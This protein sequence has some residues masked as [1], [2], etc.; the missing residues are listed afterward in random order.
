VNRQALRRPAFMARRRDSEPS[1][2]NR[3]RGHRRRCLYLRMGGAVRSGTNSNQAQ[4]DAGGI[5]P[6]LWAAATRLRSE[7]SKFWK[8]ITKARM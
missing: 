5:Y 8:S 4:S 2:C 7:G 6:I 1:K 3:R